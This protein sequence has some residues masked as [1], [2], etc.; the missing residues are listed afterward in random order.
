MELKLRHI[1]FIKKHFHITK[2]ETNKFSS[3]MSTLEKKGH[4]QTR[5]DKEV[6]KPQ[7]K[8]KPQTTFLKVIT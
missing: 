6:Q 4:L 2:I 5:E 7:M 3:F 1:I 8:T